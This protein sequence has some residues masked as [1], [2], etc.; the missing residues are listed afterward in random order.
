MH[1]SILDKSDD[2]KDSFYKEL[3]CVF[4]K[5]WKYHVKVFLG[6]FRVKVQREDIFRLMVGNGS[7]TS[8]VNG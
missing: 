8:N 6:D 2:T 3:E 7:L 4:I 5:F 1:E